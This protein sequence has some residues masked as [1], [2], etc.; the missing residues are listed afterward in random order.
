MKRYVVQNSGAAR[1]CFSA[2][3]EKPER[4]AKMTAT[5]AEVEPDD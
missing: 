5:T 3:R 1:R 4:L 2:I